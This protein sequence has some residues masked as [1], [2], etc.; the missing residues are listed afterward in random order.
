VLHSHDALK[1]G[2][3]V[4]EE[5]SNAARSLVQAVKELRARR[6]SR[7]GKQVKWLRAK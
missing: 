3:A 2:T 6:F 7:P 1:K 5:A 4:Q